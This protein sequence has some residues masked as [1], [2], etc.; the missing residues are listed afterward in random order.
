MRRCSTASWGSTQEY[1]IDHAF[2]REPTTIAEIQA[3]RP[4]ETSYVNGQVL[5][6]DYTEREAHL[7]MREMVDT[8]VLELVDRGEV[9]DHISLSVGLCA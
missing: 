8:S 7:V 6:R 3:Y 4:A 2:G 9:T 1:L 5:P